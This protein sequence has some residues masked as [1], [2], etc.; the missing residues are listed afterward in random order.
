MYIV[1]L[2]MLRHGLYHSL[3]AEIIHLYKKRDHYKFKKLYIPNDYEKGNI[4]NFKECR[5]HQSRE[6]FTEKVRLK[7]VQDGTSYRENGLG[8]EIKAGMDKPCLEGK[9]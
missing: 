9:E 5:N 1:Y 4:T 6:V 2:K 8:R 3:A 7:I